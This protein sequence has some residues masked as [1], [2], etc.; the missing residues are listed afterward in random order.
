MH[1]S[2]LLIHANV[3]Q[4]IRRDN[5]L[6]AMSPPQLPVQESQQMWGSASPSDHRSRITEPE[7]S[8]FHTLRHLQRP[9]SRL[10]RH[11]SLHL[12]YLGPQFPEVARMTAT[13]L[14]VKRPVEVVD[15]APYRSKKHSAWRGE[16]RPTEVVH[17]PS[18]QNHLTQVTLLAKSRIGT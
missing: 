17:L 6:V 3:A 9:R 7:R 18:V 11:F 10:E 2:P 16:I 8:S 4:P 5:S 12:M 13:N 14:I 1:K 15:Q